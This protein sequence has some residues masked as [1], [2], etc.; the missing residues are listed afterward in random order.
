MTLVLLL[1]LL[2]ARIT[3]VLHARKLTTLNDALILAL[4]KLQLIKS[5]TSNQSILESA[6]VFA[7]PLR[8]QPS[9]CSL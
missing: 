6:Q 4:R 7:E 8:I 5:V 3:G 9:L 2:S 1:H